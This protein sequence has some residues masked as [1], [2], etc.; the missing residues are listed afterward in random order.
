MIITPEQLTKLREGR[1]TPDELADWQAYFLPA[2]ELGPQSAETDQSEL[3][4]LLTDDWR[5]LTVGTAEETAQAQKRV[6]QRLQETIEADA[7]LVRP[8]NSH[9]ARPVWQWAVAASVAVL[10]LASMGVWQLGWF[11][12]NPTLITAVNRSKAIEKISLDDGSVVW[13]SPKSTVRYQ[14]PLAA[15]R[16]T[17]TLNGQAFFVVTK[18]AKRPFTVETNS[19]T[20]KV[21][22][23]SFTVRAFAGQATAEVSVRTGRVSVTRL[24]QKAE[25]VLLPNERVLVGGTDKNKLVKTVVVA[26]EVI[27]PAVV[28]NRFVFADTPVSDV[29][30]LLERAYNVRMDFDKQTLATCSFTAKLTDQPL[31]TKLDIICA[32][33]GATYHIEGATIVVESAG[34]E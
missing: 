11:G 33:I 14:R 9:R 29:F 28:T 24:S 26:P 16:R 31:F 18:D 12:T 34:C 27:N 30:A 19:L 17:L 20:V 23:T 1:C 22:G 5:N 21:L 4:K 25:L 8:L 10:L 3:S 15:D 6:W 7:V 13:L 2:N 32:S